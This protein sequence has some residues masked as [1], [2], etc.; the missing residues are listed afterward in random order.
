MAHDE[1]PWAFCSFVT[2]SLTNFSVSDTG[3]AAAQ[4]GPGA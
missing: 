4:S 1:I 2:A 3:R